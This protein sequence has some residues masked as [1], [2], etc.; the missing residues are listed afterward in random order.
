MRAA[1]TTPAWLGADLA[2]STDWIRP[3]SD[4][5]VAECDAALDG[6]RRRGVKWPDFGREDFPLPT[7]A[8][9]LDAVL[10]ELEN[11]RGLELATEGRQRKVLTS[12][13][14]P[15]EPAPAHLGQRGVALRDGRRG[16][17]PDPVGRRGQIRSDPRGRRR[18]GA[19]H[20]TAAAFLK[21]LSVKP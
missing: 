4:A 1:T 19:H 20:A 12:E 3:V 10:D 16:H 6:L 2:A 18:G 21:S 11:G 7:F 8:R 5:A 17:G 14:R 15:R 13:V 9:E